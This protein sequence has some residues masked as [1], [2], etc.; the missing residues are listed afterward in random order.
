MHYLHEL[1]LRRAHQAA[2]AHEHYIPGGRHDR[3][4][5]TSSREKR[6]EPVARDASDLAAAPSEPL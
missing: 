5:T 6:L 3:P 2:E 1:Q 4:T